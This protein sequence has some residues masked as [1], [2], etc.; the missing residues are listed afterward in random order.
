MD[1]DVEVLL[2]L[3]DLGLTDRHKPRIK[4]V[5]QIL[6]Q[7]LYVVREYSGLINLLLYW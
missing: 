1:I 7:V 5:C 2:Q 3:L 6:K 4:I